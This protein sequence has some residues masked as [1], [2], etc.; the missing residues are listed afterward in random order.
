MKKWVSV[1]AVVLLASVL[2]TSGVKSDSYTWIEGGE[3]ISVAKHSLA[4]IEGSDPM[5]APKR[6]LAWSE[7]PDP[8]SSPKKA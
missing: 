5:S 3:P 1:A 4:Y 2:T 7:G 6:S 8:M